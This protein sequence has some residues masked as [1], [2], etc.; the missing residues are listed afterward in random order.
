MTRAIVLG[1]TW[2]VLPDQNLTRSQ[3]PTPLPASG[4]RVR[5]SRRTVQ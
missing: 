2:T 1:H 4:G 3:L 5:F